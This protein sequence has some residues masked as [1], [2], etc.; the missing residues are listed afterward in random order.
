MKIINTCKTYALKR[1]LKS[2]VMLFDS[3]TLDLIAGKDVDLITIQSDKFNILDSNEIDFVY[4]REFNKAFM[5]MSPEEFAIELKNTI[6]VSAVFVG[7]DYRF[8]YKAEGDVCKLKELGKK[9][10]FDVIVIDKVEVNGEAVKSSRIRSLISDGE[11]ESA[12]KMLGRMFSITGKV[13]HG[14][15]NGHKIGVPTA[16][17]NYKSNMLLPRNGVYAGYTIV[18]GMRYKS[19]INVGNNPTFGAEKITVESHIIDFDAD[20]YDAHIAVEFAFKI[21]DDIKFKTID[22]LVNQ[23]RKD[24]EQAKIKLD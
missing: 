17:I 23:I 13:E 10:G 20:I 7:Y 6:N 22:D 21:R 12:N 14:L 11:I 15:G 8:G 18:D 1:G 3:H 24:I 16:N 2:G 5:M 19:V 4:C 9:Y